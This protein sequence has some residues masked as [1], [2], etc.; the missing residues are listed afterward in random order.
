[1][2]RPAA[3]WNRARRRLLLWV[4]AGIVVFLVIVGVLAGFYV[5]ILWFREVGFSGVFWGIFWSR[6]VLAVIFG[7]V[8]FGLLYAN[9]LIARRIRP[10]YRPVSPEEE[11]VERY[12]SA[13]EPY[14]KWVLPALSVL[15]ALIAA[16]GVMG[17]WEE[18]QLWR[19]A[20]TASF[21][22]EDP[23]FGRDVGFYVLSL[24]F[25]QF[26]QSWLFSSLVIVTLVTAAAHY[27]WGGIRFRAMGERVT[28]QVKA[29]LS[30]LLG[31]IVLVKAWGYRLGQFD[32]L[33]SPRGTV[34]GAS[35]TDVNA[36][37][38]ALRLLVVI[39]IVC[40][41][42]FLVNIRFRGWALPAVGLGLL[43]LASIFAG[44]VFPA[45]IQRF[46]VAPQELQREEEFIARNI[47]FTRA[48]FDLADVETRTFAAEAELSRED[49]EQSRGVIENIRLW[50]PDVLRDSYLQL[51]RIRPY[52]EFPDVDVDRYQIDGERR[53][54]MLAPRQIAQNG[55][56]GGGQTWQNQHLF[57]THGYG[58]TAS[59]VDQITSEGAPVFI[60]RDI[61]PVG[62]LA[63]EEARVYFGEEADVP[64]LVVGTDLE[65][66]D[67]PR[68]A[69]GQEQFARTKYE[70][71]G[72][73]E[74]GG[75]FRR[76][77]FAWRYRDVNLLISGL[78]DS[79]SRLLINT[80]LGTRVRKVAPFLQY[81]GDPYAAIV[82]GRIVWIWD[83]YTAS[84]R[85]PYSQLVN[86]STITEGNLTG[87]AN[88]IRNSVK[89][90]VDALDG[91]MTFYVADPEDPMIRA[92]GEVFPELLTPIGEA[93]EQLREHFRYPE[94]LFRIQAEQYANYHVLDPDQ[95]YAKEDFWARPLVAQDPQTQ[96][97]VLDPYYVLMPLPG[98]ED[99]GPQFVLFTPF[100]PAER[101]N[102]IAWMAAAS[103]PEHYGRL[104]SYEFPTERNVSGPAQVAALIAQDTEVAR[105]VSLFNQ[106]GSRV[107]Y[108]DL[109]AIPVGNSFLFVQPLYLR[110]EQEATAIPELKRVVVV[111][112]DRVTFAET[113]QEALASSFGDV[114]APEPGPGPGQELPG[115]VIS[116]LRQ[117]E[118]H[119][120][121]AQ[122]FLQQG[123]L[124]GYQREI[125]LAMQAV[126]QAAERA[127]KS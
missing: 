102:M 110:S 72:G 61:P 109:L 11:V 67:F 20:D 91:T 101:P 27:L 83:A 99:E 88:Y 58:V 4:V 112:G 44:A 73:I 32:L 68:T 127:S 42:L 37:L 30:V 122:E 33:V 106:L 54:V 46:Q 45:A 50:N 124:A 95:F 36:H 18:F 38:P 64:F 79:E 84:S 97:T 126:R 52:Y 13:V 115:D 29:H 59:R 41:V 21:G 80:D 39:A 77:L 22:V 71:S 3:L 16:F 15:F 103:D 76:L 43:V 116:L 10:Q 9:L 78:I 85:Y 108:G 25:T 118:E 114:V 19:V 26:I 75:F 17:R 113:L 49:V 1:M 66:L 31:L 6:V 100:I 81:D 104:L 69:A 28:P 93:S 89:V 7:A 119:F 62:P 63:Q 8:F 56:P 47:E 117:A 70:G 121:R 107:I 24:P 53:V 55:I 92:W 74:V 120:R 23:V 86:L 90:V 125:E 87:E 2:E 51:Q 94:D 98:D 105:E 111:H 60:S 48:G 5:D 40:A 35:Y 34:T 123:D 82:D 57:Y 65:E 14:A 12:R 96:A